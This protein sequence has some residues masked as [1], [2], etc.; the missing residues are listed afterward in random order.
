MESPSA[1]YRERRG[2]LEF[3]A[4]LHGTKHPAVA[5]E[6]SQHKGLLFALQSTVVLI[7]QTVLRQK[8]V[9]VNLDKRYGASL[10][11]YFVQGFSLM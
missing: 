10:T 7:P 1:V 2:K 5:A 4:L 11:L 9:K 8:G 3:R 6:D